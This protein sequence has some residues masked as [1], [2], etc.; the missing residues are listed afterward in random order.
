MVVIIH[1]GGVIGVLVVRLETDEVEAV[2]VSEGVDIVINRGDSG[3]RRLICVA[4]LS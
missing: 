2:L 4:G 1:P 3:H